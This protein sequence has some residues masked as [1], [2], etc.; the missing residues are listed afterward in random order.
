MNTC[1]AK[2]VL[3]MMVQGMHMKIE[4]PSERSG[5]GSGTSAFNV[6]PT[7]PVKN[8]IALSPSA[9]SVP[10]CKTRFL[11]EMAALSPYAFASGHAR[12]RSLGW[13]G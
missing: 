8:R 6:V 4:M 11:A 9:V 1:C 10:L 5:T 2:A 7:T 12:K 3:L 13:G